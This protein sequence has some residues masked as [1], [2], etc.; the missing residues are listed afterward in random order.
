[1]KTRTWF[2]VLFLVVLSFSAA[3]IDEGDSIGDP[4]MGIQA[5]SR[6]P[7]SPSDP[8]EPTYVQCVDLARDFA[9]VYHNTEQDG[10][11]I[12]GTAAN[13]W[14]ALPANYGYAAVENDS[15][16][17]PPQVGDFVIWWNGGSG[18][19]GIVSRVMR[20]QVEVFEQNIQVDDPY[21]L[22]PMNKTEAGKCHVERGEHMGTSYYV[23]GWLRYPSFSIIGRYDDGQTWNQKIKDCYDRING[24]QCLPD[25]GKMGWPIDDGGGAFV[26]NW[27]PWH[28][29]CQNFRNA[30]GEESIIMYNPLFGSQAY[31]ISGAAWEYYSTGYNGRYGPDILL[32]N[33]RLLGGPIT[34]EVGGVQ[35]FEGGMYVTRIDEVLYSKSTSAKSGGQVYATVVELRQ[36]DG[37]LVETYYPTGEYSSLT[38]TGSTPSPNQIILTWLGGPDADYFGVLED[39]SQISVVALPEFT[40]VG[41]AP[42]TAHTYQVVAYDSAGNE[43]AVS[44]EVTLITPGAP[45]EFTLQGAAEGHSSVFL[46]WQNTAYPYAPFLLLISDGVQIAKMVSSFTQRS[47]YP[48]EPNHSYTYQIVATTGSGLVL[49]YSN[50]V[51]VTTNP[52]PPPPPPEDPVPNSVQMLIEP[53]WLLGTTGWGDAVVSDQFGEEMPE[54]RVLFFSS[55]PSK[56]VISGD[57]GYCLPQR[58]GT[59]EVWAEVY[60]RRWIQSERVIVEVVAEIPPI[61]MEF[62]SSPLLLEQDFEL[63]TYPPYTEYQ[64][65]SLRSWVHNPTPDPIT[66]YGIRIFVF[67]EDGSFY[68]CSSY[69]STAK[70]LNPGESHGYVTH[71]VRLPEAG[72]CFLWAHTCP[73]RSPI[74]ED[75]Q[76]IDQTAEGVSNTLWLDVYSPSDLKS[77]LSVISLGLA[78]EQV[79]EGDDLCVQVGIGDSGDVNISETFTI[80]VG[81]AGHTSQVWEV[82]GL[83]RGGVYYHTFNLG[84]FPAGAYVIEASVDSSGVVDEYDESNNDGRT[85][86]E[87]LE[88]PGQPDLTGTFEVLPADPRVGQGVSFYAALENIGEVEAGNC[89]VTLTFGE[90]VFEEEVGVMPAGQ[91]RFFDW[92]IMNLDQAGAQVA[93]MT[94]DSSDVIAESNEGNNSFEQTV[95]VLPPLLP[96]VVA[97]QIGV[98]AP[99]LHVGGMITVEAVI[100]SSGDVESAPCQAELS[101]GGQTELVNLPAIPVGEYVL[102]EQTFDLVAEGQQT[103]VVQVDVGNLLVE[104]NEDN[105]TWSMNVTVLP[106]LLANLRITQLEAASSEYYPN[107]SPQALCGLVNDGDAPAGP[108]DFTLCLAQGNPIGTAHFAGLGIGE[109]AAFTISVDPLSVGNWPIVGIVDSADT[110]NESDETDNDATSYIRVV[111]PPQPDLPDLVISSATCRPFSWWIF[112]FASFT[113]TVSNIGTAQAGSFR[114]SI[115]VAQT[116][117]TFNKSFSGLGASASGSYSFWVWSLPKGQVTFKVTADSLAQV[118]E[119][120]ESNNYLEVQ[121]TF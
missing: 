14:N 118:E 89:L 12:V 65:I 53:V 32:P 113:A 111:E 93:T 38:V 43:L 19:V 57:N 83:A 80:T 50:P 40:K 105:N 33:G 104:S 120:D 86:I 90:L 121:K 77:D 68:D 51:T 42:G 22:L 31:R 36:A 112:R 76:V 97:S 35:H 74:Y 119:S 56:L 110:V 4:F 116:G 109:L 34:N 21:R 92:H 88:I 108:F 59:V 25:M 66:F 78:T 106:P 100:L 47:V 72:R 84:A 10:F 18:H 16:I 11:G 49:G 70:V 9:K 58:L 1:M 13:M 46:Q 85:I 102:I 91:R 99:P 103:A 79:Y 24:Y 52:A 71:N 64:T 75:W 62:E 81:V 17:V 117:Q 20:Y 29:I 73:E 8:D 54:E 82:D 69:S 6:G 23:K 5:V 96:D 7:W 28:Y 26:H 87:V 55:D 98:T 94:V 30:K 60:D 44:N 67:R 27:E 95:V 115:Q 45:G 107:Q 37:T 48:L 41:L 2:M 15:S 101:F 3:A 39:G 63:L 114:L 61:P